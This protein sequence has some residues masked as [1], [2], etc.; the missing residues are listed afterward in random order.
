MNRV[1]F[2]SLTI[3]CL[4]SVSSITALIQV[5]K[6]DGGTVYIN[7]DGSITPS[8]VP[9]YS[10]NNITYTLTGNITANA[11]GIAIERDNII[12]DGAGYTVTGSRSGNGT[13]LIN[14]SNVAITNI[15]ITNFDNGIYLDS[16]SYNTLSDNNITNNVIG[17]FL[18]ES[19]ND[20]TLSGNKAANNDYGI[21]LM[22]SSDNNTLSGNKVANNGYGI[23]LEIS[24]N[25]TLSGN[26]ATANTSDGIYLHSS[27][28]CTLSGNNIANNSAGIWL[29]SSS[30]NTLSGNNVTNNLIGIVLSN[31]S[32][33]SFFYNNFLNN[34]NYQAY[35]F[36]RSANIWDNGSVGNYWSD[37]LTKY[38][39]ATQVDSSGVWNTPYVI[40]TNN[41]DHYPLTVPYVVIPEFPSFLILQLMMMTTL[42]AVIIYKK[43]G[44]K[45]SQS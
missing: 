33:N 41:I 19:S 5:V 8:T 9:I 7:A 35:T 31:S 15:T 32:N 45:T 29:D 25:N 28:T 42:L 22:Y 37:F 2:V 20:N 1:V 13:T 21:R 38:P 24:S 18:W 26:N 10:L 23:N 30:Y 4:L 36:A 12:L 6:A 39:N 11:D 44:E 3:L 40:D 43:K 14:I 27:S 17:I 34:T 16:S